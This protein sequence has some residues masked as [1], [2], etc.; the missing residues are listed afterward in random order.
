MQIVSL[1]R[2]NI[3][4]GL[5]QLGLR[6][7]GNLCLKGIEQEISSEVRWFTRRIETDPE[8]CSYTDIPI[9]FNVVP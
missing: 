7:L 2:G 5:D 1:S 6:L 3:A 4:D 8:I 9:E